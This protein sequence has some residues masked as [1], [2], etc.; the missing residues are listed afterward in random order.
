MYGAGRR[1]PGDTPT[2]MK[3]RSDDVSNKKPKLE[4]IHQATVRIYD[5]ATAQ[6][7]YA[8]Y[9]PGR[10]FP[11]PEDL[12]LVE[13]PARMPFRPSELLVMAACEYLA[14]DLDE[15]GSSTL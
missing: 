11:V 9:L 12:G 1:T 8:R 5:N 4:S 6:L 7:A 15:P 13:Q 3:R 10:G 14:R 2:V